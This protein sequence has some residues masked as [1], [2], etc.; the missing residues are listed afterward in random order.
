MSGMNDNAK[1]YTQTLSYQA[2]TSPYL[3]LTLPWWVRTPY[4]TYYPRHGCEITPLIC[5][6]E[7]FRK[8]AR[9]LTNA[10]HSVDIIAWG[11][12]P[13]MALERD[14]SGKHGV[15]YGNLLKKIAARKDHPVQVRLLVWH[16]D[17]FTQ[18]LMKNMPGYYGTRFPNIGSAKAGY[19]SESHQSY[20][21]DWFE[22]VRS[23]KIPNINFHVRA[24]RADPNFLDLLMSGEKSPNGVKAIMAKSYRTHHQKMVLIDY[25]SPG[26]A[27]GYVMG[28]NSITDFWDTKRHLFR[29]PRRERLYKVNPAQA[30]EEGPALNPTGGIYVP[31]YTPSDYDLEQKQR[32]VQA[33]LDQNSY[34]AKPY[35]DVSCRLQGPVLFDLNHNFC[36]AWQES[37]R[38]SDVFWLMAQPKRVVEWARRLLD[39][40]MDQKFIERR[41]KIPSK[42]FNLPDGQHSVQLM[43][44]HP[45]HG[46]KAIKECY[47]NLTRQMQHYIFIQ[48]QYIQYEP[49]TEHLK[50]C[51]QRVRVAGCAN[52]IYVFMLTSTP[53]SGGMDLPTYDVAGKLGQSETMVVEHAEA[54]EKARQGK[55]AKP[56]TP[57][58]MAKQ[59]INVVMGSLWT[60]AAA[61][62]RAEDYEEIYIHA[63]VAI[64]DDA[65]FTLG[66]ANLNL[67]SMAMDSELNVLSEAQDVAYELR[68]ALFRQCSGDAGPAKFGNMAKTFTKWQDLMSENTGAKASRLPLG[69][70]LLPFHVDREPGSPIV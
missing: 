63:K 3:C 38:P 32:A 50:E 49:W 13:G 19:F 14:V 39:G 21:A 48:N 43:R 62:R 60:C 15:R 2:G 1:L 70:Q 54:V 61:P 59:G 34:I 24:V 4:P 20:N 52:Q 23:G 51:V 9:D 29:D 67:R 33:Y 64:V 37:E 44:T 17:V 11:F 69:S 26:T 53:E 7:V 28:H 68:T 65:A 16:D 46:E 31:G 55:G 5:G 6:Q 40:E 18:E 45:M 35:Q 36:E 56:I 8:I 57:E 58:K 66:S 47:A 10:K 25:E 12:D 27:I 42:A 30:W 41:K 22:E